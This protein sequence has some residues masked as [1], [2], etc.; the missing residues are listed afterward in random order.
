MDPNIGY[1]EKT[2]IK[3]TR[4]AEVIRRNTGIAKLQDEVFKVEDLPTGVRP[5]GLSVEQVSL[6][7]NPASEF[8]VLELGDPV[9]ELLNVRLYDITGRT[10]ITAIMPAD[11]SRMELTLPEGMRPGYYWI[12]MTGTQQS[13][14]GRFVKN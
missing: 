4:L 2:N 6:Y 13:W 9:H 7:P 14:L 3:N 8:V 11:R 10:W 1:A 12:S 5:N